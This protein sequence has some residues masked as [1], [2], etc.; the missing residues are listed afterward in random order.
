MQISLHPIYKR[1]YKGILSANDKSTKCVT[2]RILI[3]FVWVGVQ[4]LCTNWN[5]KAYINDQLL[6]IIRAMP[7]S[8]VKQITAYVKKLI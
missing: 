6:S 1:K 2:N 8:N 7:I 5:K 4:W 3:L